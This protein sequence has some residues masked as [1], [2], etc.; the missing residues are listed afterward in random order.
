VTRKAAGPAKGRTLNLAIGPGVSRALDRARAGLEANQTET[1]R[2]A[3]LVLARLIE[4]NAS[5]ARILLRYQDGRT[6]EVIL[7]VIVE[8]TS[9]S[10]S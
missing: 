4:A 9:E 1:V 8:Q 5:G 7:A 3:I 2:A 10:R 6:I